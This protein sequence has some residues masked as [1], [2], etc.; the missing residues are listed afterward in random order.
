MKFPSQ[1]SDTKNTHH[2]SHQEP[3]RSNRVNKG[4]FSS[5]CFINQVFL[6]NL[7]DSSQSYT[8]SQLADQADVLT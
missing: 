1:L 7:E 2:G 5:D 6:S 4:V 3:R 8:E